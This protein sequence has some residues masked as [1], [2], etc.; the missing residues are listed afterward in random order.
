MVTANGVDG[1]T[2]LYL[3]PALP[4]GE[5]A[6]RIR[7]G[8]PPPPLPPGVDRDELRRRRGLPDGI[9]PGDLARAGWGVVFPREAPRAIAEALEVL[10]DRRRRQAGDLYRE[11]RYHPGESALTFLA[12]HG[13][14]PVGPVDPGVVPYYLLLVGEPEEIP[15][16]VEHG[17]GVVHAVGRL[18]L[19][20]LEEQARYARS[21]VAAENG[22]VL[23]GRSA[24][25]FAPESPGDL[26]T[27]LSSRHLVAPLARNLSGREKGKRRDR[28]WGVELCPPAEATRDE[29]VRH[30]AREGGPAFLFTASHGISFPA[31]D[32]RQRA[33]Q[34]ALLC[35]DWPG[36]EGWQ[37]PLARDFY[38][39]AEDLGPEARV[40]GLLSFHFACHGLGTPRRDR[41]AA[42]GDPAPCPLAP[43]AFV[44]ALPRRLLALGALA[45]VGHVDRAWG[46]S[47][48]WP[49]IGPQLA[50]FEEFLKRLLQGLPVGHA[51]EVFHRRA[52]ELSF[53][54]AE[55]L[56]RDS[57]EISDDDNLAD[58]WLAT[59][60]AGAYALCGDPAVRLAV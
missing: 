40:E 50:P 10:L 30:L 16:D 23:R 1:A 28:R 59:R 9:P 46:F 13:A 3:E 5:L 58:L 24:A 22:S 7:G 49:G 14:G 47:F 17:L 45:V 31:G 60:D 34:G 15:Y 33:M 56:A 26:P 55:H 41:F 35:G 39:A 19:D 53:H 51:L 2:G 44:A 18:A 57:R 54:L 36:P 52:G 38:F 37:G 20:S 12:R 21:V 25:F 43:E 11:L 42:L 32:P 8:P 27:E 4:V 29:L 6:R 48:L